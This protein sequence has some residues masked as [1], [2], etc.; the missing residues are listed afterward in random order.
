MSQS[1]LT[2][3]ALADLERLTAQIKERNEAPK[4]P[5][6]P[7]SHWAPS[8]A[9]NAGYFLDLCGH[10]LRYLPELR[11]WRIWDDRRW[12]DDL[13]GEVFDWTVAVGKY[14]LDAARDFSGRA[15]AECYRWGLAST[16]VSRRRALLET[17]ATFSSV[18]SSLTDYDRDPLLLNCRNGTLDLRDVTLRSHDRADLI[19]RFAPVDYLPD[20]PCP[21]WDQFLL[22]VF[23]G[24][25]GLVSFASRLAGYLLTG[26]TE[27]Q[28]A[29][30][31]VG[32]G[33]NG[34]SVFVETLR[35]LL[36]DYAH[37]TPAST[38]LD[39]RNLASDFAPF[40][41]A[42][43]ITVSEGDASR[44]LNEP[45]FKRLTGGDLLTC[46]R[47]YRDSF[48][49]TPAFKLLFVVNE[50]PRLGS[51]GHALR[52]RLRL[53]PFR[54]TFYAPEE[55]R[56][57]RRDEGLRA[58][59][60]EELP[61]ILAWA[62]RGCQEWLRDGLR[63]PD[64]VVQETTSQLDAADPL[65]DFL[66]E[67]CRFEPTAQVETSKLWQAYKDYC[68][69]HSRTPA[70][71]GPTGFNRTLAQRDGIDILRR[72]QGR[73]LV[74]LGLRPSPEETDGPAAS[75]AAPAPIP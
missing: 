14:H 48:S 8:D 35:D 5:A 62:V 27:E 34:K 25:V 11:L 51:Q 4:P 44:G 49:Y 65:A 63:P 53:L 23:Q 61:G 29:F 45:L 26:R 74:G 17:A 56:E 41:G 47:P 55:N 2:R 36:G 9:G 16:S 52:R 50:L 38:F 10:H 73:Y 67:I 70:Y 6:E 33:A 60:Q 24:D 43:L 18:T 72:Y 1:D 32:K 22:E 39:P 19:S 37:D 75:S 20:A 42:R 59:L 68:R 13:S 40:V 58:K 15:R 64:A 57:P 3:A 31:L 66:A 69:R 21:R 46:K 12:A 30:F 7:Y 71:K 54:Q 28:A